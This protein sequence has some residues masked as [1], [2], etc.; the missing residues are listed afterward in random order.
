MISIWKIIRNLLAIVGAVCIL[1]SVSTSDYYVIELGQVEPAYIKS[2][3][4]VGFLMVL[5]LLIHVFY[6][7]YKEGKQDDVE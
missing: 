7:L 1:G 4:I 2:Q 5:P 6:L 3:L